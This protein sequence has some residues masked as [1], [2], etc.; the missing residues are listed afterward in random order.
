MIFGKET[1]EKVHKFDVDFEDK[2][3]AMLKEYG[4]KTIKT[5]EGALVNYAIND[6]L[7]KEVERNER[8]KS[9]RK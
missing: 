7:R 6:I 9:N 2:E 3:L 4:L 8:N 1:I 5:D